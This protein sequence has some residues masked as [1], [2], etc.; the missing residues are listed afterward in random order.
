M[1]ALSGCGRPRSL[2]FLLAILV[3]V[4]PPLVRATSSPL[5]AP[6]SSSSIR[7]NRSFDM[8]ESK[9]RVIPSV[10]E[11]LDGAVPEVVSGA[12]RAWHTPPD[13]ELLPDH[14]NDRSP[15]PLRGPPSFLISPV[16]TVVVA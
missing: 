14:Q 7:L 13:T 2:A 1:R 6:E 10:A 9:W 16:T 5:R 12:L 11:S 15:D 8:P 4:L 3:L